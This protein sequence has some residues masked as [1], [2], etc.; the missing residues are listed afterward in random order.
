LYDTNIAGKGLAI[1]MG[2]DTTWG[3]AASMTTE[4]T[5]NL[6]NLR[7]IKNQAVYTGNFTPPVQTLTN[8][9]V[10]TSG[11]NV[12]GSIT[13]TTTLL[14][15]HTSDPLY[16]GTGAFYYTT[17]TFAPVWTT[18]SYIY[19][20]PLY[21]QSTNPFGPVS[22][23]VTTAMALGGG[24]GS[25]NY[26]GKTLPASIGAN[27]GGAAACHQVGGAAS[28]GI[29]GLPGGGYAGAVSTGTYYGAG[30]AGAGGSGFV[31]GIATPGLGRGGCGVVSSIFG[32]PYYFGGGGGSA[33]YNLTPPTPAGSGGL[34]GGGGGAPKS[35]A[36]G[37]YGDRSSIFRA[38]DGGF[39]ALG[40]VANQP[41][42]NGAPNS[43]GG[44]GGGSH[45]VGT[46]GGSGGSGI[47]A[48]SYPGAQ[49]ALGGVVTT[50][51]TST[52][53]TFYANGVFT[54]LGSPIYPQARGGAGG[55][56]QAGGG[57]G[58][59]GM[60]NY[61]GVGGTAQ[62]TGTAVLF[63]GGGAGGASTNTSFAYGGG[64][65]GIYSAV[66][67]TIISYA[68]T[69]GNSAD[70]VLSA[71]VVGGGALFGGGGAGGS[72]AA[73][74][75][76]FGCGGS[77]ALLIVYNTTGTS[78]V[79]PNPSPVAY[80]QT[81]PGYLQQYPYGLSAT[82]PNSSLL[83]FST[84]TTCKSLKTV[85]PNFISVPASVA[86]NNSN[87]NKNVRYTSDLNNPAI[88]ANRGITAQC[89][90]SSN[91]Q[92]T[93]YISSHEMM[94]KNS[95]RGLPATYNTPGNYQVIQEINKANDPRLVNARVANFIVG[96]T[97][98]TGTT[99]TAGT[100]VNQYW[101]GS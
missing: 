92:L 7:I 47:V 52:V 96:V 70:G 8:N 98:A 26:G 83:V 5:G 23:A 61:G 17:S 33:S 16:E 60:A 32:K 10:G 3:T 58:A 94:M 31:S 39:G 89:L 11:A 24:G 13:G 85:F 53:H 100:T 67:K 12:A 62:S 86:Y 66:N 36:G 71:V 77:G 68:N 40:T 55:C 97:G 35:L 64:G 69:T 101:N 43:G 30:G 88:S 9:S 18:S 14:L 34:G 42:G 38:Q 91:I 99:G 41:G 54:L 74:V 82:V 79:F 81:T 27:G 51:G 56:G 1:G 20:A 93:T 72:S 65:A 21:P 22:N 2:F 25:S 95:D 6:S 57:G 87:A 50:V 84:G 59:A 63:G 80:S 29:M 75:P 44:G 37:G 73:T 76:G 19:F 78:Y 28:P 49:K 15:F 45:Q 4:Y 46:Y 48:I 90:A